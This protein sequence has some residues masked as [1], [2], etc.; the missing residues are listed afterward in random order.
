MKTKH[1]G[2]QIKKVGFDLP[3]LPGIETNLL[4]LKSVR[5]QKSETFSDTERRN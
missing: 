2:E 5:F 4:I 1:C 3:A